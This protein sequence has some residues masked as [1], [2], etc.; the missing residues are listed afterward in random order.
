MLAA[1]LWQSLLHSMLASGVSSLT[2][3]GK[4]PSLHLTAY[5]ACV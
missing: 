5:I 3:L 4:L 2:P 1:L